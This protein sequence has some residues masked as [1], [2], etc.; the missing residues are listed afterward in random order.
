MCAASRGHASIVQVL[1]EHHAD[2]NMTEKVSKS[3][4]KTLES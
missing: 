2:V 1:L 4:T 3:N